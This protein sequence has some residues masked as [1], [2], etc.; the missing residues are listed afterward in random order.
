M[1]NCSVQVAGAVVVGVCPRAW[2]SRPGSRVSLMFGAAGR[3]PI[4]APAAGNSWWGWRP[5]GWASRTGVLAGGR[6]TWPGRGRERWR[7]TWTRAWLPRVPGMLAISGVCQRPAKE[8]S[9]RWL[10]ACRT[11]RGI[12]GAKLFGPAGAVHF[13]EIVDKIRNRKNA[14]ESRVALLKPPRSYQ[15]SWKIKSQSSRVLEVWQWKRPHLPTPP[16]PFGFFFGV[17]VTYPFMFW[18]IMN[19]SL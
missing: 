17:G 5:W 2:A 12:L 16:H 13:L 6:C 18:T 9:E 1:L 7:T 19:V 4:G 14:S 3:Q 11:L 15:V 10:I 8:Y